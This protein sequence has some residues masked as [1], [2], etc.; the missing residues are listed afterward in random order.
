LSVP[1]AQ[2]LFLSADERVR[3][4]E[5]EKA[6]VFRTRLE[7]VNETMRRHSRQ[8]AQ[9]IRASSCLPGS[10][11]QRAGAR[12]PVQLPDVLFENPGAIKFL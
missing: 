4:Q 7:T 12:Q 1:A 10:L 8:P 6:S 3:G 2:S 11:R 9:P 5:A